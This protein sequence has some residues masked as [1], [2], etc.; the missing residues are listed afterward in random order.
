[1]TCFEVEQPNASFLI[2]IVSI[3][4]EAFSCDSTLNAWP[5][6]QELNADPQT[7][8]SKLSGNH[9]VLFPKS[10]GDLTAFML[11]SVTGGPVFSAIPVV[12]CWMGGTEPDK[13]LS[14]WTVATAEAKEG[15]NGCL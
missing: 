7:R 12:G 6:D 1:M 14:A 13:S 5:I 4:G 15:A 2:G 9:L 11:P 10:A 8:V 3:G